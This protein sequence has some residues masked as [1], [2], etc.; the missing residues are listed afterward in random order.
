MTTFLV[1]GSMFKGMR[2][3]LERDGYEYVVLKDIL[4]VS[5]PDVKLKRRVVCDFSSKST[6]LEA[7]DSIKQPIDAV[8]T[9]YENYVR[10][11]AWIAEYMGLPGLPIDAAEACTDKEIMRA[12][13]AT[14]P[15]PISPDF[16]VISTEQSLIDFANSHDFPLII[17]PA[18][19]AKS[20]L[21]SRSNNMDELLT[22]YHNAM[23][24]I[25]Q[26][27]QRY[28]PNRTPKLL[29]EEFLEGTIH[30]VDTFV[31][32]DGTVNVL[33]HVVDYLTGYDIGY[34]DNFHYARLLPS[35]LSAADQQAIRRTA[36]LG[37]EALNMKS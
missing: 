5:N 11:T 6:I 32:Q 2:E 27:Y 30:S 21:V 14:S 33:D 17:K 35:N 16:Q 8:I 10:P 13:F 15:E 3:A 24:Q 4:K 20:L 9:I 26:I 36:V 28:A 1:V 29:V 22:H 37:C 31:D 23:D 34:N 19:L 18:N 25:H 12:R 7:V